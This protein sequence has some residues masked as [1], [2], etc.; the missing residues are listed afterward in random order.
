MPGREA[1]K[2]ARATVPET[3]TGR[4]WLAHHLYV[5]PQS[6]PELARHLAL[7]D[8]LRADD[9]LRDAY[10]ALKYELAQRYRD[11]R[12]AYTDAKTGFIE[13]LYRRVGL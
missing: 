10:A 11:D 12:A 9:T 13:A 3:G 4:V 8:A 1:F 2:R 6:S 7:R 5:C